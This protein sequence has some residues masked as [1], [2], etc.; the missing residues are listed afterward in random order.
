M[1]KHSSSCSKAWLWYSPLL[2]FQPTLTEP[3][4]KVI[5][6]VVYV[7]KFHYS[8][9]VTESI[10]MNEFSNHGSTLIIFV[11][12]HLWISIWII[13]WFIVLKHFLREPW[14]RI[15]SSN[16]WRLYKLIMILKQRS[17]I[18]WY[19]LLISFKISIV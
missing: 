18:D 9:W 11:P 8:A 3:Q 17:H 2:Y 15:M 12:M 13:S 7:Y 10:M 5:V 6:L 14:S 1:P 16:G 19:K 4:G